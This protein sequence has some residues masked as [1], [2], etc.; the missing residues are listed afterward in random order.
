MTDK[1]TIERLEN[2]IK[3]LKHELIKNREYLAKMRE[4]YSKA[5]GQSI[6][7]WNTDTSPDMQS[8]DSIGLSTFR[9]GDKVMIIGRVTLAQS[10]YCYKNLGSKSRIEFIREE[11]RKLEE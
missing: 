7:N 8:C 5:R 1:D 3:R 10:T 9:A 6:V 4:N 11:T 2:K